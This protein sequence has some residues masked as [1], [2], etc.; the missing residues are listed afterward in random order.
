MRVV[1]VLLLLV[2]VPV[3]ALSGQEARDLPRDVHP[4]SRSRLP[5]I[6]R[7]SLNEQGKKAYDAAVA[8]APSGRPEGAAAIRLHRSGVD[9]RW[10]SPVG[11]AL[12]ELAIISTAREHDQPYEWSLHEMEAV[13]VGLDPQV[14]DIVRNKKA[15]AGV[16]EREAV[17]LQLAR[18]IGRHKVSPETYARASKAFSESDLV[19]VVGLMGQYAATATR[20]SAFNQ[21]MP[22]GWKQF[23]PLPFTPPGDFH[24]DSRSRLPLLRTPAA[25]PA[26]PPSLYSRQMA[27]EGTGP[28][29]IGRHGAGLKSL[30]ASVGQRLMSVAVLVTARAHDQ[31]YDWTINEVAAQ[32]NGL[33]PAVIDVIRQMKPP[34]GLGEKETILIQF[35][36]ELFGRRYV[37]ADTYARALQIFGERDLV[38][39]VNLMA[40]HADDA[41]MLTAFDQRLPAAQKPLLPV[42]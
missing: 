23:L 31:Q 25:P 22:P 34:A 42:P 9:V 39:F 20:L 19:D 33:E 40:Q 28:G 1:P 30:E 7:E 15:L 18:E 24:P 12:T 27:P 5:V 10:Q 16:G 26:N 37:S 13:A 2:F 3:S 38:D 32:K 36:R 8:N 41:T 17:V 21:Q 6:T 11:R 4:D 35:G 14:I 29:Q